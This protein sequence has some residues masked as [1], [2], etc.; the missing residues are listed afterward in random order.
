SPTATDAATRTNSRRSRSD[1]SPGPSSLRATIR[2]E[3]SVAAA[4]KEKATLLAIR[5]LAGTAG[6]GR[7]ARVSRAATPADPAGDRYSVGGRACS[8]R[9]TVTAST[10]PTSGELAEFGAV[11]ATKS[12]PGSDR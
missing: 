10:R 11:A 12:I 3:R 5:T 9:L 1:G 8:G 2:P 6:A 4:S 7:P